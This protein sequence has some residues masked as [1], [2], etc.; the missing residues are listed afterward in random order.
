MPHRAAWVQFGRGRRAARVPPRPPAN[1]A[2]RRRDRVC[3]LVCDP[4]AV[5]RAPYGRRITR[6]AAT[7][8]WCRSRRP[9]S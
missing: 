1:L 8:S 3:V 6:T 4:H 7:L 9:A 2:A 5:S